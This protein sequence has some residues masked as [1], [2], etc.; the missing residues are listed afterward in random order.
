M[1]INSRSQSTA[2]VVSKG[3]IAGPSMQDHSSMQRPDGVG[4]TCARS[5][6]GTPSKS[7]RSKQKKRCRSSSSDRSY[8]SPL[9]WL[10]QRKD[11]MGNCLITDQQ[12][13]AGERLREDFFKGQ[14]GA[15]VTTNWSCAAT[16]GSCGT[17]YR[18]KELSL[19]EAALA[20]RERVRR[21]LLDVGPELS[22]ILI[23]VCCHLKKLTEA[24]RSVGLPQRSGK[25]VLGLAL[26]ALA[27]HYGLNGPRALASERRASKMRHWGSDDYRPAMMGSDVDEASDPDV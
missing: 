18:D 6:I 27:R 22:G 4:R 5:G 24:E 16:G 9:A 11:R 21:A 7:V 15:R 10:R 14:M 25:V 8:E 26:S 3:C 1:T 23:D 12:F 17:G 13:D 2:R 19:Q 20:A